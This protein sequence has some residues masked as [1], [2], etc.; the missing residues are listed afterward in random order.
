MR[1]LFAGTPEAAI[2]SLDAIV[3]AGHDVVGVLTR[4]PAPAG[5]KRHL[6]SSPVAQHATALGLP[7][8][9]PHHPREPDFHQQLIDLAPQVCP[10]VAYGALLPESILAVPDHG[11]VNLHFSVLP[12]WRGAA[13]AQR[14][15]IAGDPEVGATTFQ[16]VQELD[17]GPVYL[18]HSEPLGPLETAG[19]VLDRLAHRGAELLVQTLTL[20]AEGK[21]PHPQPEE[22]V[23]VAAKLTPEGARID[24]RRDAPSL[25]DHI[26]GHSPDPGAWT[27]WRGQRLKVLRTAP[28]DLVELAP[29]QLRVAKHQVCVGTGAGCLELIEVQPVGKKP[30]GAPDWARGGVLDGSVLG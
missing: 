3:E 1:V 11:W 8:F 7:V 18:T 19:E 2:P 9:T 25:H 15:I 13:P 5:R 23:T 10:V 29:G 12:R 20:I 26:R 24:W 22:S 17:A 30:M 4:P 27:L 16:I 28:A 6:V 21:A 14:A